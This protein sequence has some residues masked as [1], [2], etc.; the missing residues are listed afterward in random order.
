MAMRMMPEKDIIAIESFKQD[1]TA[2]N[3]ETA[4]NSKQS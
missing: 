3:A 1:I 4:E 2:E